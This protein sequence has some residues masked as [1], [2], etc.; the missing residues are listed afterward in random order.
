MYFFNIN[1]TEVV[2]VTRVTD[3]SQT[4]TFPDRRFPDKTFPGQ[5]D[6]RTRR[7]LDNY[8]FPGQDVSRKDVSRTTACP[9]SSII[10][11]TRRF[12]DNHFPGQTFP[13]QTFPGQFV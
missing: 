7:F 11:R 5:D 8:Y 10:S 4:I 13:G 3:V 12:P 2:W 1:G 6:S 9:E